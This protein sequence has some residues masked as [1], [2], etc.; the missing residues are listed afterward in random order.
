[1]YEYGSDEDRV[2]FQHGMDSWFGSGE[3]EMD[4]TPDGLAWYKEGPLGYTGIPR[5]N[6]QTTNLVSY[7]WLYTYCISGNSYVNVSSKIWLVSML[8][9]KILPIGPWNGENN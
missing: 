4:S 1:M 5:Q 9:N 6:Y 7:M 3:R 2:N 8:F